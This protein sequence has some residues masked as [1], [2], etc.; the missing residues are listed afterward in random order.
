MNIKRDKMNIKRD[1]MNIN[2]EMIGK[3][4]IT[5]IIIAIFLLNI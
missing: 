5:M 2:I 1:K 4:N 3:R